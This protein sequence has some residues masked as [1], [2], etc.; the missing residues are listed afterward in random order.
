MQWQPVNR[1]RILAMALLA[2]SGQVAADCNYLDPSPQPGWITQ[3]QSPD[4]FYTGTGSVRIE[5]GDFAGSISASRR[6]AITDLASSIKVRVRNQLT[7]TEAMNNTGESTRDMES[8]STL[9][10]DNTL[11]SVEVDEIWL[12]R[13]KC[14]LWTRVKVTEASVA[15][16]RDATYAQQL[17]AEFE[18]ALDN[19]GNPNLAFS[20]RQDELNKAGDLIEQIDFDAL[21]EV[22]R[23]TALS[24]L[25]TTREALAEL[26]QNFRQGQ[27]LLENLRQAKLAYN[28]AKSSDARA[29][30]ARN[31]KQIGL[32]IQQTAPINS[33]LGLAEQALFE[34]ADIDQASNNLC[35]ALTR[36]QTITSNSRNESYQTRAQDQL[37]SL[38]CSEEGRRQAAIRNTV[39]AQNIRLWCGTQTNGT[40]RYWAKAC[41]KMREWVNQFGGVVVSTKEITSDQLNNLDSFVSQTSGL[42]FIIYASGDVQARDNPSNP[43]GKDYRFSGDV[44]QSAHNPE[45]TL[46]I[47]RFN[48][49]TG[50][51]PVG[52]AFALDLLA[53]NLVKRFEAKLGTA[54]A[55]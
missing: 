21:P 5:N 24:K 8:L 22:Q 27:P 25:G 47:D 23:S 40:L 29:E 28:N 16:Q 17:Y 2:V 46:M 11:E 37:A 32:Q 42:D 1:F 18:T 33:Q 15:K 55:P 49:M 38:E 48:G 30:A 14:I 43:N 3:P 4:G 19:T 12:D 39:E 35:A 26:S 50:W 31:A 34:L 51:N 7:I 54:T 36:L 44:A 52:E 13:E 10:V 45:T 41:D 9:T 6:Q 53:L 20:G